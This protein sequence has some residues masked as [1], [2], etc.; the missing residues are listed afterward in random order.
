VTGE[1]PR[2][3]ERIPTVLVAD[4]DRAVRA[5]VRVTLV[6][7]GWRVLEAATPDETLATAQRDQPQIVLL[8]VTFEGSPQDGFAICRELR[9]TGA[10]RDVRVV[11]LTAR[12]DAESRA[13]ASAVGATAYIV[14]PFGPLDLVRMLQLV[15]DQPTPEPGLGLYLVDAG[16]IQPAQLERALA[17]QRLRQGDRVP[18]GAILVE[19]E[20]ADRE[21]IDRA[22]ARQRRSRDVPS[23]SEPGRRRIRLVI[24]DDNPMV[25][26]GLRSAIG[27]S[28]DLVIV[29]VAADGG[30]ALRLVRDHDPD[31]IVLDHRMPGLRGID[32]AA[33]L[34]ADSP[35]VSIVMF[36][37]DEGIRESALAAGVAAFVAKDTPLATLLAEIRRV[38]RP[39]PAAP[40]QRASARIVVTARGVSRA[41]GLG[42]RRR[43]IAT[44]GILFVVY[45]A[46]FLIAE[47]IFGAAAAILAVAP[48]AI[49]G[50]LF[51]P[52]IGV[53]AAILAALVN[54]PLW[55][56]TG[57][58]L[59]EPILRVG[60]NGLGALVLM[61]VGAGFGAMRLLRGRF[62][63]HGRRLG[64]LA[65]VALALA[66]G[67]T[68]D[69]LRL[70]AEGALEVVPADAALLYAVVPTGGLELV[71]AT[72]TAGTLVGRR[73]TA[74]ELVRAQAQRHASISW[75]VASGPVG[76][77]VH[78]AKGA[79][80]V[81]IPGLADAAAGVLVVATN[82][83]REYGEAHVQVLSSYATFIGAA[84][85]T[86]SVATERGALIS[87]AV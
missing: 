3:Q 45:A 30:E 66:S 76:R 37:L 9:T 50:A 60:S 49:A 16:V 42:R 53:L 52:E 80:I 67:P 35:D 14:K 40:A 69:V 57:H 54:L 11:M 18:L 28:D 59:G 81:P 1:A 29:G 72:G 46:A 56:A 77:A 48:V 64:A 43:T 33:R 39:E 13:F 24:A 51:G 61:G 22:L 70:L 31:V 75:D 55:S 83:R 71:A 87:Q 10:T 12:D 21:D 74:G 5:L 62:D 58:E 63:P 47:P 6:A 38:A 20:L 41:L 19:M 85:N 8:D 78:E 25:R 68:P 23:Q 36:T 15:L 79:I 4:D 44:L 65:E 7:Q 34:R 86:P 2:S 84:L 17:E 32:V 82:R 73:E 27:T 26:E